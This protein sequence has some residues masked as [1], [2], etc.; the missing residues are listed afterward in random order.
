MKEL[1]V[2]AEGG[3]WRIA[4]AFDPKRKAILLT[5]GNKIGISKSRFYATLIRIADVRY[6][7]YLKIIALDRSRK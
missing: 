7:R 1:R 5:G 2:D 4:F 6:T 3:V